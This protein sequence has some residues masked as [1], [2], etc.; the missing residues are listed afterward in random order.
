MEITP[1]PYSSID[2]ETYSGLD[3][4]LSLDLVSVLIF[5]SKHWLSE[6]PN[7]TSIACLNTPDNQFFTLVYKLTEPKYG[8]VWSF[9]IYLY[10]LV[11]S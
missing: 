8:R 2:V 7:A 4:E 6:N 1:S 10:D 11:H 9:V 5:F 3:V